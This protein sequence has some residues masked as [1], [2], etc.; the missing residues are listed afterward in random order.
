[1]S[2]DAHDEQPW[3]IVVL[4][5]PRLLLLLLFKLKMLTAGCASR[6]ATISLVEQGLHVTSAQASADDH[7]TD[8]D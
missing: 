6:Q 5:P 8:H 7:D 1:M 2:Y 3:P 4:P